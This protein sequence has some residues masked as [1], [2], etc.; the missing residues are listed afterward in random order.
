MTE[1]DNNTVAPRPA[2]WKR[3]VIVTILF[4]LAVVA[5]F[6]G[7]FALYVT[8]SGPS[9]D[10]EKVYV[11]IPKGA[12]LRQ[13]TS[14]LAESQ[15]IEDDLRFL[16][17]ARFTGYSSRLQAGE[18]AL[19]TGMKPMAVLRTLATAHSVKYT[20][21]IPEGFRAQD[22]G[23][24]FDREG[25]CDQRSFA[26]LVIDKKFINKLGFS[27][28][29]SLEGYLFPDTYL[30]TRDMRGAENLIRL[31][32]QR[33]DSV[34]R[35]V[36]NNLEA[37][38]DRYKTVVLASIVEKETAAPE[39]RGLIAGVFHNRLRLGMRLQSD[40][41]VLYGRGTVDGPITRK[42]LQTPTPYN[43][44]TLPGLPVGPICNPGRASL[45]AV[46]HPEVTEN[47]YFVSKNNGTHFFSNSLDE[48]NR[49]VRKFQR[50]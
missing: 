3:I 20:V 9:S 5:M 35:D 50:K 32:V 26:N 13:I 22:I 6:G 39:E 34:W 23:L 45:E 47:L 49:A 24:L 19:E 31:L 10:A 46:I 33:F 21:T 8:R 18:F 41:T 28:L 36:T 17:L 12:S 44:Y 43:T 16:L 1:L 15:V 40:P 27:E 4:V 48:H 11:T 2:S 42:E 7:W 38:V 14:T 37:P 30:L 29:D 25:W